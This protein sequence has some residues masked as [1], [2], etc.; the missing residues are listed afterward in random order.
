MSSQE[1]GGEIGVADVPLELS[2]LLI[3]AQDFANAT[4]KAVQI[5][6]LDFKYGNPQ[7]FKV[8]PDQGLPDQS[9]NHADG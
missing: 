6:L 2:G 8:T 7:T 4:G 3:Q 9:T 1:E 5:M